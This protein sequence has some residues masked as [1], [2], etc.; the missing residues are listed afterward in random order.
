[1]KRYL[2][3]LSAI[4]LIILAIWGGNY[5]LGSFG[6]GDG[7]GPE[8][9]R[10][11]RGVISVLP[12]GGFGAGGSSSGS[13]VA[14]STT[15]LTE[16]IIG[17]PVRPEGELGLII[18]REV[19]D[20]AIEKGDSLVYIQSSGQ[21]NRLSEKGAEILSSVGISNLRYARFS[22]DGKRIVVVFGS[23]SAPQ[24]SVFNVDEESWE[25]L[26]VAPTSNPVWAPNNYRLAYVIEE[27]GVSSLEIIDVG[28]SNP[29]AQA[30]VSL[31]VFD[32]EVSWKTSSELILSQRATAYAPQDAFIYSISQRTIRPLFKS[33]PGLVHL[34]YPLIDQGVAFTSASS[35]RGGVFDLVG[36]DGRRAKRFSFVA[37]PREKCS[38]V[39]LPNLEISIDNPDYEEQI[40]LVEA[41]L[42]CAI[43]RDA[44]GYLNYDVPDDYWKG[45]VVG[46]E[47]IVK[48]SLYSGTY[49]SVSGATNGMFDATNIKVGHDVLYFIDKSDGRLYGLHFPT[50]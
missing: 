10:D 33:E 23:A 29:R 25:P 45:R 40:E 34:W 24:V 22:P 27:D 38:F 14:T 43:P 2:F 48:V 4:V 6:G 1:M 26:F 13:G 3:L 16:E 9:G 7:D 46:P 42:I 47:Q 35:L 12:G 17:F 15:G 11:D 41:F 49:A 21:V 30:L 28:A 44:S 20:Y 37:L 36:R 8:V 50:H 31:D 19:V 18:D 39:Q 32:L 5:L